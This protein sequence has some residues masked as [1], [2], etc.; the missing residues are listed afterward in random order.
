MVMRIAILAADGYEEQE[1]WYPLFRLTEEGHQAV[2]ASSQLGK[3]TGK[4][5]YPVEPSLTTSELS[6]GKFDCAIIPGGIKGAEALRMD[7]EILRFVREMHKS[8]K[9]IGA[10]C[11]GPWVLLSSI[12]IKGINMTCYR[13]MKDDLIAAGAAYEDKEVITSN[14][15]ITSRMPADLPAFMREILNKLKGGKKC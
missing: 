11:H 7:K 1:F 5:G 2:V 8:S 4:Y 6:A 14:N 3:K 10:I 13:G 12:N 9:T 15:I